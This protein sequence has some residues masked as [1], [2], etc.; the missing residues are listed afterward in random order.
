MLIADERIREKIGF[1]GGQEID[2]VMSSRTSFSFWLSVLLI[3]N[4]AGESI[5]LDSGIYSLLI[6]LLTLFMVMFIDH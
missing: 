6:S 2:A 3:N 5:S 4:T 1:T